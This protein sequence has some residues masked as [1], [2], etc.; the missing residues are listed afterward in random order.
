MEG[1]VEYVGEWKSILLFSAYR[2]AIHISCSYL[3]LVKII[4][5]LPR[6]KPRNDC[7]VNRVLWDGN[8]QQNWFDQFV[9][10]LGIIVNIPC[11]TATLKTHHDGITIAPNQSGQYILNCSRCTIGQEYTAWKRHMA[12]PSSDEMRYIITEL[13]NPLRVSVGTCPGRTYSGS[14]FNC[15]LNHVNR[16]CIRHLRVCN[17]TL[18]REVTQS[19]HLPIIGDGFLPHC[20]WISTVLQCYLIVWTRTIFTWNWWVLALAV[21]WK[22][23]LPTSSQQTNLHVCVNDLSSLGSHYCSGREQMRANVY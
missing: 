19:K 23:S 13:A 1:L 7:R 10:M 22:Y 6:P 16:K 4:P 21:F 2:R 14:H 12:I 15:S 11:H 8:L 18:C 9:R 5:N 17:T 20:M 3:I